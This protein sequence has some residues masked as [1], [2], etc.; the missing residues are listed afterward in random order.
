MAKLIA[1]VESAKLGD[2]VLLESDTFDAA[3]VQAVIFTRAYNAIIDSGGEVVNSAFV[4]DAVSTDVFNVDAAGPKDKGKGKGKIK[5][6][7][8]RGF[9][10]AVEEFMNKNPSATDVIAFATSAAC[11]YHE[12]HSLVE[13]KQPHDTGIWSCQECDCKGHVSANTKDKL[14]GLR[15]HKSS[16]GNYWKWGLCDT[17]HILN[18]FTK[19]KT[20]TGDPM[21]K[22]GG[23]GGQ[24]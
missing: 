1:V 20:K 4:L 12:R 3:Q 10:P 19:I 5:A 17:H 21:Y 18:I 16:V 7:G 9:D 13:S 22:L 2:T 8:G 14:V 6:G 15:L 24:K 23:M 11:S